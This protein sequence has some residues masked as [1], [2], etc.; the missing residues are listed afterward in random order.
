MLLLIVLLVLIGI[1]LLV[2][3]FVVIPGITIA[4]IGGTILSFAGIFLSYKMY[5]NN[6]G[7][8]TLLGAIVLFVIAITYALKSKTWKRVALNSEI[9]SKVNV[10]DHENLHVGDTGI[11]VSRLAPMGKARINGITVEAKSTGIYIA[12][13]TEIEIIKVNGSNITVKPLN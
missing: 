2:L 4:G 9:K 13:N 7:S 1:I 10:I 12:E 8:Y 11:A 5:G 6:I 3:E